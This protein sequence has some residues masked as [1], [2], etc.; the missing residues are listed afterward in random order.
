VAIGFTGF[1]DKM[2]Q[3]LSELVDRD[4]DDTWDNSPDPT[5][6]GGYDNN[7][8]NNSGGYSNTYNSGGYSNAYNSNP[9]HNNGSGSNSFGSPS[10]P[11]NGR[12]CS[13]C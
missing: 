12:Y 13:W 9:S 8:N 5:M 2:K 4:S 6:F 10:S 7:N 1:F 3:K 11:Y